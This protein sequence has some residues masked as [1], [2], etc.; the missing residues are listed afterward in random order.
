M[1][2]RRSIADARDRIGERHDG[3]FAS[4]CAAQPCDSGAMIRCAALILAGGTGTR[5]GGLAPKQY[6][7]VAGKPMLRR[8]V[9]AFCKH[10][11]VDL[12]RVVIGAG[13]MQSY[14][15]ATTGLPVSEPVA[16]GST[17]QKSGLAGLESMACDPPDLVLI[18]DAARPLVDGPI[19]DRIIDALQTAPAALPALAINDTLK[20][21]AGDPP[22]V[23]D[24][25]SRADLWRAQ[26]PQGF[27]FADILAAHRD[28]AGSDLTD[29]AAVAERAGLEVALV[30]GSVYNFKITTRDDLAH[31]ERIMLSDDVRIGNGFD[32]HAF[33]NGDHVT[34]CG[35]AIPHDRGLQGHSD[36][37]VAAHAITDALLGAIAA[38]DIG[39]RFPPSEERWRGVSSRIFLRQAAE[40]IER[41]SGTIVNVDVTIIC[42]TP[43]IGPYRDVMRQ[44]LSD[45]LAIDV[46]RVG[47]KATTTERLGFAGRG[48]GIAAQATAAVRIPRSS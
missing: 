31:A 44:A 40:L 29:D 15:A 4:P 3:S 33:G 19:I 23:A 34:L 48:E 45:S 30:A 1:W 9:E 27:R 18:H 6:E 41:K 46:G 47:V 28:A 36:A 12:V 38:D 13:D 7:L 37:D 11:R 2:S 43:K 39:S 17:R 22:R 20:R 16:G 8:A 25:M 32:V 5:F 14:A 42:E 10:P 24:T 21:A 35:V 26:T